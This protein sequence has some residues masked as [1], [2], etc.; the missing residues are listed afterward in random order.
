[1]MERRRAI[2]MGVCVV[3]GLFSAAA[4][5]KR[6]RPPAAPQVSAA[7][8][9]ASLRKVA[10]Y[11]DAST[12][13]VFDQAASMAP[14]FEQLLRLSSGQPPAAVHILHFGDSH[15]AADDWTGGLR[16]AFQQRFGDGASGF[17]LAGH[18]FLGYRR[19]DAHGGGSK[20]WHTEG[21]RSALGDGYFGLGGVSI[22]AERAGQSAYLDT[23]C[24]HLEIDYFQQPGG[25]DLAFDDN[26]QHLQDISTAGDAAAGSVTVDVSPGVH[27][28]VLTTL[29]SRPVRLFGWV[30]DRNKGVTYEALGI[31]GAEAKVM[32]RWDENMLATYLQRRNP[33]LIVLA[34]GTNAAS[35]PNWDPAGYQ[36]MFSSLLERLR[37]AA[38]AASILA[39]GPPDRWWRNRG[40]WAPLP[41]VDGIIT[42]QRMACR[43]NRCAFWDWRVRMGGKG[44]MRDWVYA[45]LAQG[46][47]VHFTSAGY[48]RLAAVLFED[49]MRQYDVYKKARLET[50]DQ[51]K[52]GQA[53]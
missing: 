41:G 26:G 6:T 33:G 29:D 47:Y 22:S 19:F 7:L 10:A 38:P 8:R 51:D 49:M 42:A 53:N 12:P 34:Y 15:T 2:A 18:P 24:D 11:L 48:R 31:N 14:A 37:R 23:E 43:D 46:D 21:L 28:F 5:K 1:M 16:E 40:K 20:E 52:H 3:S 17:S 30:A 9:A 35:D 44:S 13:G 4:A 45:G 50:G 32:L 27:H 39:I 25:G 36:A